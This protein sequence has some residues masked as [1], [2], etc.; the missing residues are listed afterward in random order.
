M[1]RDPPGPAV[2]EEDVSTFIASNG[3]SNPRGASHMSICRF[4]A[5]SPAQSYRLTT[6]LIEVD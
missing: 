2:N 5:S 6:E 4:C 1:G 3:P